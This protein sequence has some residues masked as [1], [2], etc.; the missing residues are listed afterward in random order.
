LHL[1]ISVVSFER[2]A[3]LLA[4]FPFP[5]EHSRRKPPKFVDKKGGSSKKEKEQSPLFVTPAFFFL[6]QSRAFGVI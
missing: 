4:F 1:L 6:Y 2:D 5:Q 3:S